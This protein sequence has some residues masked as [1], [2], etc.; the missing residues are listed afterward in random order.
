VKR[1]LPAAA[2]FIASRP[3]TVSITIRTFDAKRIRQGMKRIKADA[4]AS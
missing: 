1:A 3:I 2:A 4:C